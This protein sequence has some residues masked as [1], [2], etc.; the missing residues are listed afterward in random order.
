MHANK[1]TL[2]RFYAAF[3]LLDPDTMASCYAPEVQFDDEVFSLQGHE[4]VT[5]MWH[6]LCQ[7]M[8]TTGRA[9]WKLNYRAVV[10][11]ARTGTVQWNATYR[12]G[13][14]GRLVENRI[15]AQF[16]FDTEGRIVRHQDQFDFW[17][18]SRQALG[19]PGLLLGWSPMMRRQVRA[20]ANAGLKKYLARRTAL[21]QTIPNP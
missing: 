15:E 12:F 9:D 11:D 8:Q 16:Q 14:T 2:G 19:M 17:R 4:Q 13:A 1:A 18:W 3:A 10:A 7:S 21:A 5:G 6:M 20:R